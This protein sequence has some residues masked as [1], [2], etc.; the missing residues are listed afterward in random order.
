MRPRL[1]RMCCL[2]TGA[3]LLMAC[4]GTDEGQAPRTGDGAPAGQLL[5]ASGSSCD[6]RLMTGDGVGALRIGAHVD[7]IYR[8]CVIT[9]DTVVRAA[10]GMLTRV[11]S[12]A[13]SDDTLFA[14]VADDRI[15]RILVRSQGIFTSDSLSVG[16]SVV[17]MVTLPELRPITGEGYLYVVTPAHCGMSFRLS[18]PP[19]SLP[20]GEW[21]LADLQKLPPE[22]HVTR[23][24]LIGCTP[25]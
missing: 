3:I 1:Y 7:S 11:L 16:S 25:A 5:G 12:V 24:L 22:V 10:E 18:E 15:W 2:A 9:R 23:I 8:H 17:T 4:A 21:T 19:S 14:E 20:R 6:E 13:M